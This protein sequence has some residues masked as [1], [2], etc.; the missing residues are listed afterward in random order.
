MRP[1][2]AA[3]AKVLLARARPALELHRDDD[4]QVDEIDPGPSDAPKCYLK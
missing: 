3:P 1:E 4:D 2:R